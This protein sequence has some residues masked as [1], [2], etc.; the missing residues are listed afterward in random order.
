MRERHGDGGWT[1]TS[2]PCNL[3]AVHDILRESLEERME[4]C[5]AVLREQSQER[6]SQ[7]WCLVARLGELGSR[8]TA[9]SALTRAAYQDGACSRKVV[10][11]GTQQTEVSLESWHVLGFDGLERANLED[12]ACSRQG[13]SFECCVGRGEEETQF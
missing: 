11:V 4:L 6:E 5:N 7:Q 8:S 9:S 2:D 1:Y 10:V 12:V 13:P 3:C